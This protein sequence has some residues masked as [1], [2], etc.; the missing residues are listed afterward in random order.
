MSS[1]SPH[2]KKGRKHYNGISVS[3]LSFRRGVSFGGYR[4]DAVISLLTDGCEVATLRVM[5]SKH[6]PECPRRGWRY[7]ATVRR[8]KETVKKGTA[9][10]VVMICRTCPATKLV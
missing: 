7:A 8:T 3:Y 6:R 5:D 1:C 4:L 9:G 2:Y 10:R